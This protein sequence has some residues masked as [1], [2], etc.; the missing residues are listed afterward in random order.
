MN[1]VMYDVLCK[2]CWIQKCKPTK[3][4]I[5]KIV[6]SEYTDICSCCGRKALIVDYVED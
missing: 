3:K 5:K 6:M 2:K 1:E 4:D